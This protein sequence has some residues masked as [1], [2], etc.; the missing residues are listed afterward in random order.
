MGGDYTRRLYTF[1]AKEETIC[2]EGGGGG[3]FIYGGELQYIHTSV[4]YTN[5]VLRR[6]LC[7]GGTIYERELYTWV[8]QIQCQGGTMHRAVH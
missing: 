1:S 4:G 2:T 6:A 3:V 7:T 5:S 8:V